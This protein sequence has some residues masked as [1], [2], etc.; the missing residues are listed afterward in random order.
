MPR[1]VSA[2]MDTHDL[3]TDQKVLLGTW[4]PRPEATFIGIRKPLEQLVTTAAQSVNMQTLKCPELTQLFSRIEPY[5]SEDGVVPLPEPE[6]RSSL[7]ADTTSL[8]GK[9]ITTPIHSS[10]SA[11]IE[12]AYM[13]QRTIVD[14][15]II[16]TVAPYALLRSALENFAHMTWLLDGSSRDERRIRAL[17]TWAHDMKERSKHEREMGYVPQPPAKSGSDRRDEIIDL[18]ARLGL[19]ESRVGANLTTYDVIR[20]VAQ[21]AGYTATEPL[22]AW[23]M[24]SGFVHGRFWPNLR[25]S[26]PTALLPMKGGVGVRYVIDDEKFDEVAKWCD[27][28]LERAT[29]LYFKRA[30]NHLR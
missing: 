25:A 23:R 16:G 19:P 3:A 5:I 30:R 10:F 13:L 15:K 6:P 1:T 2:V 20:S 18:A 17:Q 27:R 28:F 24:A 7:A 9:W 8:R 21:S 29:S 14:L 22:A 26:E 4:E 11:G 12:Q